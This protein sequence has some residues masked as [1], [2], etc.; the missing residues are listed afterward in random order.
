MPGI[1]LN[2]APEELYHR[3]NSWR[4]LNEC[5]FPRKR[6]ACCAKRSA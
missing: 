4:P 3:W 1:V 5:R 6:F 2:D